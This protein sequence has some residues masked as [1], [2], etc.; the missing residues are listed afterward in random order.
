MMCFANLLYH[1]ICTFCASLKRGSLS[2]RWALMLAMWIVGFGVSLGVGLRPIPTSDL[3]I[4]TIFKDSKGYVWLGTGQSLD[5]FDGI[6]VKTYEIP[7][8]NYYLKRVNAIT[9]DSQGNIFIATGKGLFILPLYANTLEPV[10]AD[11]I[12]F[13]VN[14]LYCRGDILYAGTQ[15]GLYIL[16]LKKKTVDVALPTKDAMSPQNS[17]NGIIPAEG[18]D[19]WV[20]TDDALCL[21]TFAND[22]FTPYSDPSLTT[23]Y[24]QPC[25]VG[26]T[27][28]IGTRGEGIIPFNIPTKGFEKPIHTGNN[29][30]TSLSSNG[31]DMLYASI[32]GGG[33]IFYS[34]PRGE[35]DRHLSHNPQLTGD[36]NL[37]NSNSVYSLL[38]DDKEMIWVGYYQG[39][40]EYT[41]SNRKIFDILEIPGVFNT[42][43]YTVRSLAVNGNEYV[44]GTRDGF[45]YVN[46]GTN[47]VSSYRHP[48]LRSDIIFAITRHNGLYYIGT[49]NGGMYIFNP[50]TR[51]VSDFY[52][53]LSDPFKTG[54]I[55]AITPDKE[56][57]LWIGSSKGV[58]KFRDNK[59]V[60]QYNDRNSRIPSG[61]VYE[62]FFDSLNRGWI[63]TENGMAVLNN[64]EISVDRFPKGFFN[65]QKIRD[66]Y[67]DSAH[68]L[69]FIP[70]RGYPKRSNPELTRFSEIKLPSTSAMPSTYFAIEDKDH[71]IWF[72]SD[73]GLVHYDKYSDFKLFNRSFGLISPI[74]T[75]CNPYLLPNGDILFGNTHGLVRLN[76][77]A[78]KDLNRQTDKLHITDVEAGGHSVNHLINTSGPI[79]QLLL[80]DNNRSLTIRFSP[81]DFSL[82]EDTQ[83]EYMLEGH[84]DDWIM[85]SGKSEVSYYDLPT[86]NY[87]FKVRRPG[88][89]S[90]ET[91]LKVRVSYNL[92]AFEWIL[93]LLIVVS[94]GISIFLFYKHQRNAREKEEALELLAESSLMNDQ[95]SDT[96]SESGKGNSKYRTTRV[97]DEECKRLL[98]QLD[99]L[100]KNERTYID[101]ELKIASLA[102]MTGT[103]SHV[104]SYLFNQYL[105]SSFY[106]YVNGYRVE[107]FKRLVHT[108][109]PH[110]YT[111]TALSQMSGFSSRASFF[112]HFKKLTGITPAEY[113][114]SVHK[115]FS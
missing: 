93:I 90:T 103:S 58:Y 20:T 78:F 111:L 54:T 51:T 71:H 68:N 15:R 73:Y 11:K 24:M 61:N 36:S 19:L 85:S 28:Y 56:G 40:A 92:S 105:K 22:K 50:L 45:F 89:V 35:I 60:A 115:N 26:D 10:F 39:G 107:E 77:H 110:R 38:V 7:G 47:Q 95:E 57:N 62:I 25:R 102:T 63:C 96:G 84:D 48:E 21:Y 46:K 91:Q 29:I 8:D 97:S 76:Y 101:P 30:I 67:E 17:I 86:G 32:D 3:L 114:R 64:G 113:L 53:E 34:I 5:R 80:K 43:D 49:Y 41:T 82:P 55:F 74:F 52:P 44:V 112:R 13:A 94:V 75:H 69:Y 2:R 6:R 23:L 87:T 42:S 18:R 106:D 31:K 70:D 79:P 88:S 100:M 99:T 81:L 16:N 98:K 33:V 104:L 66:I 27:I 109:D 4:N 9:E 108:L 14:A 1:Y 59:L 83:Y 65:N 37:L 72:G 12:D